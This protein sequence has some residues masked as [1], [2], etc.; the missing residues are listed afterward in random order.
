[1]AYTH[2]QHKGVVVL[3]VA[4]LVLAA[5]YVL[6]TY[7]G[8]PSGAPV[9]VGPG[10]T[11]TPYTILWPDPVNTTAAVVV[12]DGNFSGNSITVT[13]SDTGTYF[14]VVA[15]IPYESVNTPF[16]YAGYAVN[17]TVIPLFAVTYLT[18]NM[19]TTIN[20]TNYLVNT[21]SLTVY[22]KPLKMSL[23]LGKITYGNYTA[24]YVNV[25]PNVLISAK[26]IAGISWGLALYTNKT[27]TYTIQIS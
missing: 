5:I 9:I 19:P 17:N 26:S 10:T 1:M 3:V 20:M 14:G 18:T 27:G 7:Y 6:Y 4:L 8:K 22:V 21:T 23:P 11:T 24:L 25:A 13:V 2:S 16:Y 15:Y 12:V